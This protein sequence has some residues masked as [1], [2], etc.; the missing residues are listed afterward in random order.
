MGRPYTSRSDADNQI[1]AISDALNKI[2]YGDDRQI[3]NIAIRREYG[4]ETAFRVTI[5]ELDT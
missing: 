5:M 4:P 1:K 3:A 2:A